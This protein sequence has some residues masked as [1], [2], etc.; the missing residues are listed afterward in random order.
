[1]CV[2]VCVCL[3]EMSLLPRNKHPQFPPSSLDCQ[4]ED[5]LDDHFSGRL[6]LLSK[7]VVSGKKKIR[8]PRKIKI[9]EDIIGKMGPRSPGSLREHM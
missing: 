3:L 4:V 7:F 2:Y 8:V 9:L 6:L 5:L 1:M